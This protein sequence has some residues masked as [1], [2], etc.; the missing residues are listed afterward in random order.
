LGKIT[1]ELN[2]EIQEAYRKTLSYKG[3]A[4]FLRKKGLKVD[5]RTVK[6]PHRWFFTTH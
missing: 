5:E 1:P 4:D 2:L 3:A 6:L